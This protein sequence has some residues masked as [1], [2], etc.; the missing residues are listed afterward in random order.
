MGERERAKHGVSCVVLCCV[1]LCCVVLCCVELCCVPCLTH[2][3]KKQ[4]VS[5]DQGKVGKE[6]AVFAVCSLLKLGLNFAQV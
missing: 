6:L 4:A 5:N 2:R 3:V 1:V